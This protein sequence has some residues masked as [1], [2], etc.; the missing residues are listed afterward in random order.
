[1]MISVPKELSPCPTGECAE[2]VE[3]MVLTRS[4]GKRRQSFR[5]SFRKKLLNF[6]KGREQTGPFQEMLLF[7]G[8]KA[9]IIREHVRLPFLKD[10]Q[11]ATSLHFLQRTKHKPGQLPERQIAITATPRVEFSEF[12]CN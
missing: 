12:V 1:M 8:S 9:Q 2:F 11:I 3:N 10:G 7:D 6:F 4:P 5:N